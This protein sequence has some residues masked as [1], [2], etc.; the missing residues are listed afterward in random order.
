[1]KLTPPISVIEKHATSAAEIQVA[2]ALQRVELDHTATAF[3]SVRLV[4]HQRK[5]VAEADFVVVVGD[6][7]LVLEVKGGRVA[8]TNGRW[9]SKDRYGRLHQLPE[10]PMQQARGAG[11]ALQRQLGQDEKYYVKWDA[12]V[13]TPDIAS[14]PISIEWLKG[15]WLAGPDLSK[16]L[17][18]QHLNKALSDM[19]SA[20]PHRQ[21]SQATGSRLRAGLESSFDG[22]DTYGGTSTIL[23]EQNEATTSQAEALSRFYTHQLMVTGGAGTGKTLVMAELARREAVSEASNRDDLAIL[24]TFR[25]AELA[26]FVRALLDGVPHLTIKPFG[27]ISP[28]ER[29]EVV[30]VDEAQ[31]LMNPAD[32]DLIT[33]IVRGGLDEGRWRL[34]LDPNNQAHIDGRFD[35]ETFEILQDQ[36]SATLPLD[37]NV[38]NTAPV[39]TTLK[40]VLSAD[41]GDPGVVNG[42]RPYWD[43]KSAGRLKDAIRRAQQILTNEQANPSEV[44][45]IDCSGEAVGLTTTAEGFCLASPSA[46]KGLEANHVVVFG[47]PD[48]LD[49]A[50]RA[51]IYVALT[52]PRIS[53]SVLMSSAQSKALAALAKEGAGRASN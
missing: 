25:S 53:L 5:R 49:A 47:W 31:D 33:R 36:A 19:P 11:W 9:S 14:A 45:L 40:T 3:W 1:M 24:V 13:V 29:Y 27:E 8:H 38:R 35:E 4:G 39:V 32:M 44:C 10:S 42:P 17:L 43:L 52:R 41:L 51:A 7:L 22:V 30:L 50:G 28:N 12:L 16:D 18:R 37:R 2:R 26:P 21:S 34:F 48:V 6:S 46:I 20:P 23:D 15:R